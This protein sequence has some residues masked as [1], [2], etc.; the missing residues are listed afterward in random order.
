M[1]RAD[2]LRIPFVSVRGFADSEPRS[3]ARVSGFAGRETTVLSYATV[4]SIRGA[5]RLNRW[6]T[7]SCRF[8]RIGEPRAPARCRAP[9]PGSRIGSG[10]P[11]PWR[12]C[13]RGGGPT[14][15]PAFVRAAA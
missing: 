4:W 9:S 12:S 5:R 6:R 7:R 11:S 14:T 8:L 15:P 2:S 10:Q 13:R 3:A 1:A